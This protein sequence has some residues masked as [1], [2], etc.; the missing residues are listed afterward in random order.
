MFNTYSLLEGELMSSFN[1]KSILLLAILAVA[2]SQLLAQQETRELAVSSS[3][4]QQIEVQHPLFEKRAANFDPDF[5]LKDKDISL[6]FYQKLQHT[7][8]QELQQERAEFKLQTKD[9]AEV[10]QQD[11]RLGAFILNTIQAEEELKL[12]KEHKLIPEEAEEVALQ[13]IKEAKD[14]LEGL[15]KDLEQNQKSLKQNEV[16]SSTPADSTENKEPEQKTEEPKVGNE[17]VCEDKPTVLP[18]Q[19]NQLLMNQNMIVMALM[20]LTQS[21]MQMMQ[22]Q[23]DAYRP[24]M[25]NSIVPYHHQYPYHAPTAGGQWIFQPH[26]A[27]GVPYHRPLPSAGGVYPEE[28]NQA[29]AQPQVQTQVRVPGVAQDGAGGAVPLL[30]PSMLPGQFGLD[31][32]GFN[33]GG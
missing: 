20:N 8:K 17:H 4:E 33:L 2:P 32:Y 10:S 22:Q 1:H 18:D 28:L 3:V 29:P 23:Q 7:L 5:M 31:P 11:D 24:F 19:F 21:M 30:S 25:Q 15:L 13:N 26:S 27:P 14:V 9:A 12:L 6:S 16:A